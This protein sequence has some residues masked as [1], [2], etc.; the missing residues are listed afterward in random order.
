MKTTDKGLTLQEITVIDLIK[1][2]PRITRKEM[3]DK[4]GLSED[5]IRYHTDKL[6]KI[7]LLKRVGGKK[8]GY[9]E[10]VDRLL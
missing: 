6:K 3:A 10:V 9:R 1:G 4:L 5:G 8:A 7:G 2:Y